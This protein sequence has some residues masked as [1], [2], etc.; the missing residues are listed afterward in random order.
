MSTCIYPA[1]QTKLCLLPPS[2]IPWSRQRQGWNLS[3]LGVYFKEAPQKEWISAQTLE[4][5]ASA[6]WA[7]GKILF[8]FCP[9]HDSEEDLSLQSHSFFEEAFT[10]RCRRLLGSGYSYFWCLKGQVFIPHQLCSVLCLFFQPASPSPGL[11]PPL[12]QLKLQNK[13]RKKWGLSAAATRKHKGNRKG[14]MGWRW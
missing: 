1:T 7:E 11:F 13:A 10:G 6:F 4:L 9:D 12:L 3:D 5:W 8:Y 2:R 14:W